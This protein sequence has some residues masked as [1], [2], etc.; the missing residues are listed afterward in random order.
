MPRSTPG[1]APRSSPVR[2]RARTPA[3]L[4]SGVLAALALAA[5]ALGAPACGAP[6]A[7][8]PTLR[9]ASPPGRPDG[10]APDA[11]APD[12]ALPDPARRDLLLDSAY[13]RAAALPR[14]RSLLVWHDGRL[15]RERYYRGATADRPAN[16]K[17]A[18]KSIVSALV[19][20]AVA[21]GRVA[22]VGQTLGALLPGA[23]AA[24]PAAQAAHAG[25]VTVED[26]LTMRS[27]LASTSGAFYG[28]W[29]QS[30]NW[31]QA[32]L[33]RPVEAPAGHAGGPMI[34]STGNTHLLSAALTR[35]TGQGL[36]AFYARALARP[37]GIAPRPWP[38]DPQGVAFGGNEMRLTPREM[39]TFGRLYLER[40]RAPAGTPAAGRQLVPAA[41]V[42]SS[43]APR[44]RSPWSGEAYG[45]GWFLR[46]TA[47]EAPGLPAYDVR[48]AWGYGGQF[49]FVVPALGLVV[50]TT[51]DPDAPR[52][53]GHLGAVQGLLDRWLVPAAAAPAVAQ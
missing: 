47:P 51:S 12:R 44:T 53:R 16:V 31:V 33:R 18:S 23:V 40:G 34:Y 49:I 7:A 19:G 27:G 2:R 13:A 1:P 46:T 20:V 21:E 50:V 17:S 29:V 39:V 8:A 26:L 52:D 37:L 6:A 36:P 32:A 11:G 22:G 24:L 15:L 25:A 35:A 3:A 48:Y 10:P 42:D 9:T 30:P 14:L 38:A 41:W 5:L 4:A 28:R 43:W 45:Y